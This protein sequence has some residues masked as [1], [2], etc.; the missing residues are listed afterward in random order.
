MVFDQGIGSLAGSAQGFSKGCID[1]H[2]ITSVPI[3][4]DRP[5]LDYVR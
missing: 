3:I 2:F 1:D 5:L 4:Y